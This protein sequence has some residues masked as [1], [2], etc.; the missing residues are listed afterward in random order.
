MDVWEHAF[1][2]DWRPKTKGKYVETF[3]KNL[4]FG[5]CA[6]RLGKK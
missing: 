4:D 1:M 3:F 5:A 2:V 6:T